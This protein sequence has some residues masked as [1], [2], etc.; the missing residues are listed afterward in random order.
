MRSGPQGDRAWVIQAPSTSLRPVTRSRSERW[1]ARDQLL[2]S[3]AA[4]VTAALTGRG[5]KFGQHIATAGHG[6]SCDPS[7]MGW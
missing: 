1:F 6:I 5:C 3:Q 2:V 7:L 4:A